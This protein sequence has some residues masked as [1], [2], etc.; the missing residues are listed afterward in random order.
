MLR[1]LSLLA[2]V[3]LRSVV[4][5]TTCSISQKNAFRYALS[6][7]RIDL[8]NRS[9]N[10]SSGPTPSQTS[11]ALRRSPHWARLWSREAPSF[12]RAPGG[13]VRG[14]RA[15]LTGLVLSFIVAK[16]CKKNMRWKALAE[17]YTMHSFAQLLHSP[18]IS[19]FCHNLP[20]FC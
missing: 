12:Q 14:E 2:S 3:A 15:N 10:R 18:A 1:F 13:S 4:R 7:I 9:R 8:C 20:I 6:S 11:S 5:S 17:I 16:F 19:I